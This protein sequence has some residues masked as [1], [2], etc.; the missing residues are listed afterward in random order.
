MFKIKKEKIDAPTTKH[1]Y[2]Y[3][4]FKHLFDI[5]FGIIGCILLIP[6][7]IIVKIACLLTK[8]YAPIIFKQERIGKNGE[9]IYIYK[10]RS[11]VPGADSLLMKMMEE[12]PK[13]K[14]EYTKNKKL[15]DDPRITKVG[16]IIR[17]TSIDE[18]PQFI[19]V[20][21]GEMSLVGPRPYLYREK[22]DMGDF[23]KTIV[24]CRPGITGYWQVNGRSATDFHERLVL[25][26]YYYRH[27]TVKM[28]FKIILKTVLKIFAR[29]GAR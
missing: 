6:L 29:E 14:E 4:F 9:P 7:C 20:L 24:K 25:D 1:K 8:D 12:D 23:Y 5:V 21:K 18:F 15:K 3:R 17:K 27:R 2:I 11:M 28:D 16:K 10:F 19:N 22:D 26:E 13:I